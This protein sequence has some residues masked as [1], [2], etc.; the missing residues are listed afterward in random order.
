MRRFLV[1]LSVAGVVGCSEPMRATGC[2]NNPYPCPPTGAGLTVVWGST[3]GNDA[4]GRATLNVWMSIK[5]ETEQHLGLT[6]CTPRVELYATTNG[7]QIGAVSG[8]MACPAGSSVLDL[9]PGD[10]TMQSHLLSAD[11]LAT[12]A[13]GEWSVEVVLTSTNRVTSYPVGVF[14]LPL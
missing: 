5:N 3:Q 6:Q 4:R 7:Q 12:F 9:A 11:T 14:T 10:S 2:G 1:L 8:S 13:P